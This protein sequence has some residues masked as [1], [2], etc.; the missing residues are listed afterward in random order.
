MTHCI[1]FQD[2]LLSVEMILKSDQ[3]FRA[4]HFILSYCKNIFHDMDRAHFLLAVLLLGDIF[5]LQMC[6]S[7]QNVTMM[8]FIYL[9][10]TKHLS[11]FY[12]YKCVCVCVCGVCMCTCM[13]SC[14]C[15]WSTSSAIFYCPITYLF[16]CFKWC[17]C[18]CVCVCVCMHVY[19]CMCTQVYRRSSEEGC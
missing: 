9:L 8:N 12:L 2:F 19:L 14:G 17:V 5:I 1:I 3:S 15:W 16:K 11:C 6:F 4:F 7:F 10:H 18:V 13:Y